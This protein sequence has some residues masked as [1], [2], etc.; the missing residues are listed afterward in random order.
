[1][2]TVPRSGDN[3]YVVRLRWQQARRLRRRADGVW[4]EMQR[5]YLRGD[6]E[7]AEERERWARR[8]EERGARREAEGWQPKIDVAPLTA[9]ERARL[10]EIFADLIEE[11]RR[12][13]MAVRARHGTEPRTGRGARRITRRRC[14]ARR[15]R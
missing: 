4:H 8:L 7:G 2:R 1:M 5:A 9:A 6:P 12:W 10:R 3:E 13:N 15:T 11:R 14:V